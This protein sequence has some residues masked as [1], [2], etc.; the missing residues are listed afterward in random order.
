MIVPN[1]QLV[2]ANEAF[3]LLIILWSPV[4]TGPRSIFY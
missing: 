3:Y 4:S 2:G 1:C